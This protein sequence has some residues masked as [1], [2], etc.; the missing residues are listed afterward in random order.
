MAKKQSHIIL[1]GNN[2]TLPTLEL[3]ADGIP[4]SLSPALKQTIDKSAK[5]VRAASQASLPIYGVNTGFG[6]LANKQISLEQ[7][8]QLQKNLIQ[9]HAAGFGP[10]LSIEETRLAM[11][12]RL[13]VLIKGCTGV[14]YEVC[15]ALF[16]LIKAG[17][18]P[19]IPEFGSVGASGDLAPLAHLALPLLGLGWTIYKGRKMPAKE[20]LKE[21]GLTPIK[22]GPKEGLSLINGTQVM[23]AVGGLAMAR[24]VSLLDKAD[25]ITALTYEALV[26]HTDAL[27]PFIHK[28]R[29]H[30]G[31][32]YSAAFILK[33]LKGSYL[34]TPSAQRH[35]I[36]DP[37]SLRCA[38]QVHGASRDAINYASGV[39]NTEL[40]S[41]TDNPVVNVK[42][43]KILSGGNF[44]GQ[45]LALSFDLSCMSISELC[46]ISERRL[47]QLLNPTLS[48]LP[49]F[50]VSQ[51]G[52]N[53][54]YMAAQYLSASLVNNIKLL[55]NPACTDSIPGNAGIED[56][57]SMGMTSARKLKK[58]VL[59]ANTVLAIELLAAAQ[60]VDLRNAFPLGKGTEKT[61]RALRKKVPFLAKDRIV[62]EDI[63]KAVEVIDLL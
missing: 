23:L 7:L 43:N 28:I 31:Q 1:T 20:A 30:P 6:F 11:V 46:N 55:S 8:E 39:I 25:K 29:P 36:Q 33:E 12:L 14:R 45:P 62:S 27:N 54:G 17:I 32:A 38:P 22:L 19:I 58:V 3:I 24:A 9:S 49:A 41:V 10:P 18:Y 4:L 16:S 60:A 13:N 50:L 63:A 51:E 52:L 15:Q 35:R 47:E 37:Y 59:Q 34:F 53:S 40:N 2:L 61:Y 48:G 57:V 5:I 42:E 26:G 44:H 56:H 21:A